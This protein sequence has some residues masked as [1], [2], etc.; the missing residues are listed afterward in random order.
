M[1]ERRSD[2]TSER[3]CCD[4]ADCE[5]DMSRYLAICQFVTGIVL[6]CVGYAL[7]TREPEAV[8]IGD[9]DVRPLYRCYWPG[10]F[11]IFVATLSVAISSTFK[12]RN[13]PNFL[14]A[15]F[16]SLSTLTTLICLVVGAI[17]GL[18]ASRMLDYDLN[19]CLVLS[20]LQKEL[21]VKYGPVCL[22]S[23]SVRNNTILSVHPVD[24]FAFRSDCESALDDITP[25]LQAASCLLVLSG[26]QGLMS[27]FIGWYGFAFTKK[28]A[29][30]Q[31]QTAVE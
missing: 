17:V 3:R 4:T 8:N 16:F 2:E 24:F 29:R 5:Y 14:M 31:R 27:T 18:M 12:W 13:A 23:T 11:L 20:Q 25:L 1:A 10:F 19:N 15:A 26:V 21:Y 6:L 28:S 7:I 22:C 9:V 30:T